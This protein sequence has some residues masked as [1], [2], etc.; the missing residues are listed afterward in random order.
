MKSLAVGL[1]CN[2]CGEKFKVSK[3]TAAKY[4][5][6]ICRK[7]RISLTKKNEPI[8]VKKQIE[9]KRKQTCIEKFGIDCTFNT[10]KSRTALKNVDWNLRNEKSK[11]SKK[12]K[13]DDENYNNREKANET[14]IKKYGCHS[15]KTAEVKAKQK[16]TNNL[17]Y[18]GNSP[19]SNKDVRKQAE[20][21]KIKKYGNKNNIEKAK[22]TWLTVYGVDNPMKNKEIIQ[23]ALETKHF[24]SLKKRGLIYNEIYF[25]SSWELAYYIWLKDNNI[26]FTYQPK[27]SFSYKDINGID[28]QIFPDFL[29][30][31]KL[32]EIK[33]N[34]FFNKNDEPYDLYKKSFWW[35]KYSCLIKNNIYIM[36]E[37]E[38]FSYVKYVNEKY[39]KNFLSSFKIKSTN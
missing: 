18:G 20:Q 14:M 33:G 32:I 30:E 6:H 11:L 4:K 17:R 22:E 1:I 31:D 25:D 8:E 12:L 38:A 10:E 26:K 19:I 7:C 37:K 27:I 28:R 23:K 29:V 24:I 39:G 5:D 16:E 34:Q 2:V 3:R 35:E 21:T 15:S 13:Y 36:R 9:E